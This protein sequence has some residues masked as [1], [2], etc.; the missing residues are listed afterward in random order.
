MKLSLEALKERAE[1]I[2]TEEL[3]E[4]IN[5]GLMAECHDGDCL[6]VHQIPKW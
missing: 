6:P 2:A 1:A 3:M 5:G 4:S